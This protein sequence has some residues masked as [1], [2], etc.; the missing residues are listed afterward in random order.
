MEFE[1][2]FMVGFGRRGYNVQEIWQSGR[3]FT[4]PD[5]ATVLGISRIYSLFCHKIGWQ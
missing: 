3:T 4:G 2:S 5:Y 1:V